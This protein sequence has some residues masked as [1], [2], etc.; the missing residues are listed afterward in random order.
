MFHC[1]TVSVTVS[2]YSYTMFHCHTVRVITYTYST[3]FHCHTVS[4]STYTYSTYH[5]PLS[6]S[7]C[8]Y[9]HHVPLC[10]TVS[11]STYSYTY[12]YTMF[13]CQCHTVSGSTYTMFHCHTVSVLSHV[14]LAVCVPNP[15]VYTHAQE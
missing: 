12:S 3:M 4:V 9:L 10:H 7:Q 5:V 11:V 1:H 2:T 14:P 8:Q 15:H 6:Y 13:H